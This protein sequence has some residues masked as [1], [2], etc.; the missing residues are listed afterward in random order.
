MKLKFLGTA[1]SA[2]ILVHNRDCIIR[3]KKKKIFLLHSIS[4]NILTSFE[5]K[6]IKNIKFISISFKI[7]IRGEENN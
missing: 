3:K 2:G 1:N 7:K 6:E 4:Y 5:T